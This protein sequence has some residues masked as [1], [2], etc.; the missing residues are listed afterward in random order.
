MLR[1][2]QKFGFYAR[3]ASVIE[4]ISEAD[5]IVF[6][7]TGT[8]TKQKQSNIEYL[9]N[10][11]TAEQAQKIR[12]LA[13][14]SAH[15]L[16]K[17]I[18]Q[19][20]PFSKSLPVKKF[21]NRPGYGIEG[22][23]NGHHLAIGSSEF[24][25]LWKSDEQKASVAHIKLDGTVIGKF[26]IRTEYRSGLAQLLN[27]LKS[28]YAISLLSGDNNAERNVLSKDF[29]SSLFFDQSPQDKLNYIKHIQGDGNKVIMIGDGLNDAGALKQSDVGI[30]ITDN[31]NNFSPSCDVIMSGENFSHLDSLLNYCRKNKII[32]NASFIISILY[33]LVGLFFAVRGELQPVIAAILMP[34]SS[35][36]IILL[37]TGMSSLFAV[38]LNRSGLSKISIDKS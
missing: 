2:L 35:I 14:Q 36:S 30:A 1:I 24:V 37:T 25:G 19:F 15:P 13:S 34:V 29:G 20:L 6:D 10:E 16:S 31:I 32:I 27:S 23:I 17:A 26:S 7:K 28:R 11:L 9:G 5:V 22:I 18:V 3:N 12:S 38:K 21:E 33:N 4:Q 8:I